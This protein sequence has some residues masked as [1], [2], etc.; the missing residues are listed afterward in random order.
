M[1]RGE[2]GYNFCANVRLFCDSIVLF[3]KNCGIM[4]L[5]DREGLFCFKGDG[6]L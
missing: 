6:G 3:E 2:G 5:I 4:V 1:R